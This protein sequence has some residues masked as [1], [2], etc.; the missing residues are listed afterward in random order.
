[1]AE[2]VTSSE[3]QARQFD[4]VRKGYDRAQVQ[5]FLASVAH[6]LEQLEHLAARSEHAEILLGL[7]DPEALARELSIIGSE[8]AAVLE[9][10]RAAAESLR[11]RAAAD[12]EEW[13]SSAMAETSKMLADA[14]EQSHSMRAA[15]WNEGSSML[16]SALSE[17]SALV[18]SAKEDALFVRAEAEREAIRHTGDAKRDSEEAIRAARLEAEQIIEAARAESDGVLTAAG[19]AAERAQERAHALEDRRSELLAELEAARSSIG[20][21]ETEIETKRQALEEPVPMHD[22]EEIP[23]PHHLSDGGSVRIVSGSKVVPM[24]PVDADSFVAEVEALRRG[25]VGFEAPETRELQVETVTV[26]APPPPAVSEVETIV[27]VGG[28]PADE[29]TES[30]TPDEEEPHTTEEIPVLVPDDHEVADEAAPLLVAVVADTDEP[31]TDEP[32][33]DE[34]SA[35]EPSA[36]E[37]GHDAIGSLFAQLRDDTAERPVVVVPVMRESA[38]SEAAAEPVDTAEVSGMIQESHPSTQVSGEEASE[39][40]HGAEDDQVGVSLIPAQNAALRTIKRALVDIQNDVLEHLRTDKS[41]LPDDDLV[42]RFDEAFADL[43]LAITGD[44]DDAGASRV[45]ASDLFEAATAAIQEARDAGS[46]GRAIA[47]AASKVF[48][49]W[50]SDEAEHRVVAV[51]TALSQAPV[52][53]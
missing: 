4:V 14:A 40:E 44:D 34:P 9:A 31:R 28:E 23:R 33:T 29:Q 48:R 52:S 5:S 11:S 2:E 22:P 6:R 45:F 35:D 13:R 50:R 43:A 27:E 51:A 38:A 17:A 39:T 37:P 36:D 20:Q 24:K 3:V 16:Q 8:V 49:R 46:G 1:M 10:A 21:L 18:D 41:W 53:S 7:D 47:A 15:A 25:T 42:G 12:A 30:D 26:I 19:Q 32:D